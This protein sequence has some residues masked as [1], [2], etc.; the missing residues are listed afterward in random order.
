VQ[1]DDII[2]RSRFDIK[3]DRCDFLIRTGE[4]CVLF[5]DDTECVSNKLMHSI[6]QYA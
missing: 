5:K 4:L 2:P 6:E 1:V 3:L